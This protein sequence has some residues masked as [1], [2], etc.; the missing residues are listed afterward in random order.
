MSASTIAEERR[1][2]MRVIESSKLGRSR[3][4][5]VMTERASRGE[6]QSEGCTSTVTLFCGGRG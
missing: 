4:E 3:H 5:M 2:M 6:S 1:E